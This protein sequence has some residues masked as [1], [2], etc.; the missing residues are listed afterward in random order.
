[1]TTIRRWPNLT[2]ALDDP[3]SPA[4]R[5]VDALIADRAALRQMQREHTR[6]AGTQRARASERTL[7]RSAPPST[8]HCVSCTRQRPTWL[9]L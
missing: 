7:A 4:R 3:T 2:R 6:A 8:S 5:R 1:M 9:S